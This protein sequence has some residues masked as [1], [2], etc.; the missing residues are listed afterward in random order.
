MSSS[1]ANNSHH[2]KTSQGICPTADPSVWPPASRDTEYDRGVCM[3]ADRRYGDGSG[4]T[5]QGTLPGPC[6]VRLSEHPVIIYWVVLRVPSQRA[7]SSRASRG[8]VTF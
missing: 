6:H 8:N 5:P 4:G 2:N 7:P 3:Y 1:A